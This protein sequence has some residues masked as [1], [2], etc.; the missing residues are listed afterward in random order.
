M[1]LKFLIQKMIPA[2]EQN[3]RLTKQ[4]IAKQQKNGI[5]PKD[6]NDCDTGYYKSYLAWHINFM[7]ISMTW[8][9]HFWWI[10]VD[11]NIFLTHLWY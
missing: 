6:M 3:S 5:F 10:F 1:E 11:S 9:E 8:F 7:F 4:T 2:F